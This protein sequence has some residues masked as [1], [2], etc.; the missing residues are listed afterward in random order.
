[1]CTIV[2]LGVG[3]YAPLRVFVVLPSVF[4]LTLCVDMLLVCATL[5]AYVCHAGQAPCAA[6]RAPHHG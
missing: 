2:V 4:A 6:R 3:M 5:L 1:M